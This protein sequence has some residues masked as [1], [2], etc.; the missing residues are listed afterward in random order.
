MVKAAINAS[1][2][3]TNENLSLDGTSAHATK[4][5]ATVETKKVTQEENSIVMTP[6]SYGK[7]PLLTDREECERQLTLFVKTYSRTRMQVRVPH[8][9]T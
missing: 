2:G 9:W 4:F 5:G 3:S 8:N 1:K 7:W 6:S